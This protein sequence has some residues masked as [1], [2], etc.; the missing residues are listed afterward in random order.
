MNDSLIVT[1]VKQI[2]LAIV[3]YLA[4]FRPQSLNDVLLESKPLKAAT[5]VAAETELE[6][7]VRQ[8]TDVTQGFSRNILK[9]LSLRSATSQKDSYK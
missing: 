4:E 8:N 5:A 1:F 3:K 6:A 7:Q 9:V 2:R